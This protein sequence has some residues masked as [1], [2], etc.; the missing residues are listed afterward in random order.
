[1]TRLNLALFDHVNNHANFRFVA[2]AVN[3]KCI[4]LYF[5]AR[6]LGTAV[7][8]ACSIPASFIPCKVIDC[9]IQ[10]SLINSDDLKEVTAVS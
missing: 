2:G 10:G 6:L 8:D 4:P 7:K 3:W 9:A 1:M 5:R